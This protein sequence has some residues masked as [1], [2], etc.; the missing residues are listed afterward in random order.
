MITKAVALDIYGTC[1]PTYRENEARKGLEYFLSTCKSNRLI[2]CT[3]SDGKTKDV[4]HDLLKAEINPDYFDKFFKMQR[5]KGDFTKQPKD[6]T[7]ILKYYDIYPEELTVIDDRFERGI[8][9][10]RELGCNTIWVPE[11]KRPEEK[12]IF[13]MSEIWRQI[14]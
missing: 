7:S 1:L 12:L 4:K 3:S 2:L 10:A 9:P 14:K 6:F 8:K 11:Y 13:D 5:Q